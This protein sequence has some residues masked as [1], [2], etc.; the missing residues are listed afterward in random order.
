MSST[1]KKLC[2]VITP[3]KEPYDTYFTKIIKPIIESHDLYALRGDSLFRPTTIMDEVWNSIKQSSLLI[4]ELTERNP[5]VF[6]ELG[7]AHALSKPVILISQTMEDV[8]FDLRAIR[9]IT[10]DKDNPEWGVKL[11][12]DI[13]NAIVEAIQ[14]PTA[15]IPNPFKT[16]VH[17]NIPEESDILMR[18]SD[19][20]KT[21][22]QLMSETIEQD[23]DDHYASTETIKEGSV[24]FHAKFGV[25]R[26]IS[27]DKVNQ[28]TRAQVQFEDSGTKWLMLSFANLKLLK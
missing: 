21:V 15:S 9:V 19:L 18:L 6:Y 17:T 14:N 25:G 27:I 13:G 1:S 22:R 5:N 2:F 8:P 4:A 10:Y 12:R 11:G 24:V 20:E 16:P 23:I 28:E 26:V 7:L 3:F